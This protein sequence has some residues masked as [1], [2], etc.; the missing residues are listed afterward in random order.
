MKWHAD[1][2]AVDNGFVV[3]YFDGE[4]KRKVVYQ[5][6]NTMG[7]DLSTTETEKGHIVDMFYEILEHFGEQGSKHDKKRIKITYEKQ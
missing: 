1:I 7:G 2:Q 5:N 3:D 6:L 4:G